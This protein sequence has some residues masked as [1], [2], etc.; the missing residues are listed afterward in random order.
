MGYSLSMNFVLLAI[1]CPDK[2]TERGRRGRKWEG[3]PEGLSQCMYC[4]T[5]GIELKKVA[6]R[7]HTTTLGLGT[8]NTL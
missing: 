1:H 3:T 7:T 8:H 4:H 2:V 6:T 5:N